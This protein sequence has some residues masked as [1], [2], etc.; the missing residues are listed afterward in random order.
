MLASGSFL[1]SLL[2]TAVML[3]FQLGNERS[4]K[5]VR[6]EYDFVIIGSGSAGAIVANKLSANPS[7]SML[8]NARINML[9]NMLFYT[10][11]IGKSPVN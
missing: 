10:L 3:Y 2:K 6:H 9:I 4:T 8:S 5:N 7:V 11:I 1:D